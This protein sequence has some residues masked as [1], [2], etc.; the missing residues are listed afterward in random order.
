L[1][2]EIVST[3]K[4]MTNNDFEA[5]LDTKDI[6]LV[7]FYAPW[8]V[9]CRQMDPCLKEISRE[10]ATTVKV[11]RIDADIHKQLAAE[12]GVQRLPTILVYYKQHLVW[13]EIGFHTKGYLETVLGRVGSVF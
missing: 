9:P 7:V 4:E 12:L 10:C 13:G 2:E 3:K 11:L 6:V 8:C 1:P 5:L